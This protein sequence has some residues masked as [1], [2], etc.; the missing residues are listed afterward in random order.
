VDIKVAK[1]WSH[2]IL[3]G[4]LYLHSHDPPIIHHDLKYDKVFV[5]GNQGDLVGILFLTYVELS[6]EQLIF[7]RVQHLGL[8]WEELSSFL[9]SLFLLHCL[10]FVNLH[11]LSVLED[12]L[13]T[14]GLFALYLL[15]TRKM[16]RRHSFYVQKVFNFASS[17]YCKWWVLGGCQIKIWSFVQ[18]FRCGLVVS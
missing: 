3:H 16:Q 13:W 4:I 1:N 11:S 7:W 17:A 15:N 14:W 8:L 10:I 2:K 5:N 12:V 6:N 18:V 9:G